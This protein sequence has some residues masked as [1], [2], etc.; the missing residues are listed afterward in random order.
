M[1]DLVRTDGEKLP[2]EAAFRPLAR[3]TLYQM[4]IP[5]AIAVGAGVGLVG[6]W[7][8]P[9][10][11]WLAFAGLLGGSLARR[12]RMFQFLRDN[13]EGVALIAAGDY[14]EAGSLYAQ[15]CGRSRRMPALHSLFVFNRSIV[16]LETGNLEAAVEGLRAVV[17]AGWIR[18]RGSLSVYYPSVLSRLAMGEALLGRLAAAESWQARAHAASSKAKRGALL[19]VDLI[20]EARRTNY[21][22]VVDLVHE[23]WAR[24]EN[25]L[26]TKHLR[27]V[28]LVEAFALAQ[29]KRGDYRQESRQHELSRALARAREAQ[30]GAYDYLAPAW[31]AMRDFLAMHELLGARG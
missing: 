2:A 11:I 31:P 18:E 23:E 14:A 27:T 9:A 4:S 25:L 15:L 16:E 1:G 17:Q 26:P 30:R 7:V 12:R 24:A 28:R 20:I 6:T 29:T 22:T 8:S 21:D 13:D 10:L 3:Q 19:L 5:M